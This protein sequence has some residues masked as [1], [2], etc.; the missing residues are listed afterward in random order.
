VSKFVKSLVLTLEKIGVEIYH[1]TKDARLTSKLKYSI[2]TV[3]IYKEELGVVSKFVKSLVLTLEKIGVEIYH[4]TKDTYYS[5]VL[6][7]RELVQ[8]GFSRYPLAVLSASA[9]DVKA[10]DYREDLSLS[11]LIILLSLLVFLLTS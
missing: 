8:T 2:E 7:C 3:E 5:L 11:V 4:S 1:S 9:S 6:F 10:K